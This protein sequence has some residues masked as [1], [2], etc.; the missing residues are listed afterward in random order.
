MEQQ[1]EESGP[2]RPSSW[3]TCAHLRRREQ[4]AEAP[5]HQQHAAVAAVGTQSVQW[6]QDGMLPVQ[7]DDDEDE[8]RGLHGEQL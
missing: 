1:H 7:A 2:L 3:F 8:G 6:A 4:Q 5:G